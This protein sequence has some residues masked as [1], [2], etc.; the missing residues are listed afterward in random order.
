MASRKSDA[1]AAE[2]PSIGDT[3]ATAAN[4]NPLL[5]AAGCAAIFRAASAAAYA[6]N[7]FTKGAMCA[8][9]CEISHVL[10]NFGSTVSRR[11]SET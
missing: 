11:C 7:S 2:K 10:A 6:K 9:L 1:I 5:N 4:G 3:R 8:H